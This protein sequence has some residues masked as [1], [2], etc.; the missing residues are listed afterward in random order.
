MAEAFARSDAQAVKGSVR[1]VG[2][3][4]DRFLTEQDRKDMIAYIIREMGINSDFSMT[5]KE[6]EKTVTYSTSLSNDQASIDL[7]S[8][9][10]ADD[11]KKTA[12]KEYLYVDFS[13][14][15]KVGKILNYKDQ[16]EN[17]FDK[18]DFTSVQTSVKMEGAYEGNLSTAKK[19]KIVADALDYM[20][21]ET[22]TKKMN[23]GI[24]TVYAYTPCIT[25]K[26]QVEQKDI[27]MNLIFNYNEENDKTYFYM[28]SPILNEDY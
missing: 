10:L 23:G 21:G 1:L 13:L 26:V 6:G 4:Q 7:E 19:E 22:V 17:V 27:N 16:L 2:T 15:K 20:Q 3:Y 24:S 12:G 11:Q 28:A 14:D 5:R 8:I 9:H 18:M 25:D